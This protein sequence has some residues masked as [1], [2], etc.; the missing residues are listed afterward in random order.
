MAITG[1]NSSAFNDPR[2]TLEQRI[3]L[4]QIKG[5]GSPEEKKLLN[6][7]QEFE[8]FFTYMLLKE[9]RKTVMETP[10]FHG[11][12]AEEIFRDMLDE[13][14]GKEM[15]HSGQGLG[16]ADILYQQLSRPMISQRLQA[17][18]DSAGTDHGME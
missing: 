17:Q 4:E 8:S 18:T 9:M 10:L 2:M 13:E 6:A 12:R 1:I 15:S 7:A 14:V 3:R 5:P 11:G 16:I